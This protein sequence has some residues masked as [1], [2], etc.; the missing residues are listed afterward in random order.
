[1][2]KRG[3]QE[4]GVQ[5]RGRRNVGVPHE[6]EDVP[7]QREHGEKQARIG[8]GR[9]RLED[10]E[11][12]QEKGQHGEGLRPQAD[13][14]AAHVGREVEPEDGEEEGPEGVEHLDE[15]V[16]PQ[17]DVW[18]EVGQRELDAI[19]AGEE[20]PRVAGENKGHAQE[21]AEADG[22]DGDAFGAECDGAGGAAGFGLAVKGEEYERRQEE[23]WVH[24]QVGGEGEGDHGVE[25]GALDGFG[26][27]VEDGACREDAGGSADAAGYREGVKE[28]SGTCHGQ[29]FFFKA[30]RRT[31]WI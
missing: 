8:D 6:R 23:D 25:R 22:G 26:Y 17:A 19:R 14:Q 30:L 21:E 15:E 10:G 31:G 16:P 1:M 5:E 28:E 12:A 9:V 29:F 3:A 27:G 20:L 24:G 2:V 11:D 7:E 4:R 18:G 13:G